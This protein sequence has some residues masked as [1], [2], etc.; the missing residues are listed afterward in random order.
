MFFIAFVKDRGDEL[1]LSETEFERL[2]LLWLLV[3]VPRVDVVLLD[4]ETWVFATSPELVG[5]GS[6]DEVPLIFL[7][8]WLVTLIWTHFG[9]WD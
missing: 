5:G 1:G 6:L 4:V 8:G 7:E 3:A 2:G 9:C